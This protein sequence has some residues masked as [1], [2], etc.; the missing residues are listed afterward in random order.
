MPA[1][2][3]RKD[4]YLAAFAALLEFVGIGGVEDDLELD[5]AGVGIVRAVCGALQ[6]ADGAVQTGGQRLALLSTLQTMLF[7]HGID[8]ANV[9]ECG[10]SLSLVSL[11]V[12]CP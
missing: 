2:T 4:D 6:P 3:T 7:L 8:D 10:I 9:H 5:E 11:P 1:A 12:S